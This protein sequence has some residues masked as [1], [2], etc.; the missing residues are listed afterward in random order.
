MKKTAFFILCIFLIPRAIKS[1]PILF[2][3][4]SHLVPNESTAYYAGQVAGLVIQVLGLLALSFWAWKRYSFK[5]L[6]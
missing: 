1:M 6:K 3:F 4:N 5:A 2:N